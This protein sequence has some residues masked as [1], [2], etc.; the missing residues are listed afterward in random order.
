MTMIVVMSMAVVIPVMAVVVTIVVPI[1]LVM[2][3]AP[4]IALFLAMHFPLTF[5]MLPHFVAE[6]LL[7]LA[8]VELTARRVHVVIPT[9]GHEIDRSAAGVVFV[10]V[11][12]PV[13]LVTRWHVQVK[14]R[15]RRLD[16]L[17]RGHSDDRPRHDQ[18]RRG[19]VSSDCELP[20][21]AGRV[22][23]DGDTHVTRK[24]HRL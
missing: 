3:L 23:I 14:S 2:L 6:V 7:A 20:V 18:L 13:P 5:L 4:V 12:R 21:K 19:D 9:L 24:S 22:Q 15:R 11:F 16:D 8:L 1:V 10:T 17:S